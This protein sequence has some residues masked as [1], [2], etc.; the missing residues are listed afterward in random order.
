MQCQHVR[1]AVKLC[2]IPCHQTTSTEAFCHAFKCL[3]M[4]VS[5]CL[6]VLSGVSGAAGAFLLEAG[7]ADATVHRSCCGLSAA[8]LCTTDG[9]VWEYPITM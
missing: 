4:M 7:G 8:L 5:A 6:S 2:A 3:S 1:V 9:C